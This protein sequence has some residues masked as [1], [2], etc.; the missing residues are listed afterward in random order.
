[1][2]DTKPDT[3]RLF[4]ALWPDADTR[5]ALEHLQQQLQLDG[6][7]T[8]AANFHI[9][10]A[11]LGEQPVASLPV[12][13]DILAGVACPSLP[14]NID[15]TGYF[16]RLRLAWLGMRH[17]P[18]ELL[19]LHEGLLA[20]LK[21][22]RIAIKPSPGFRPHVTLAR[23]TSAPPPMPGAPIHWLADEVV[24]AESQVSQ[25]PGQGALYRV[26]ATKKLNKQP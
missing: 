24:L 15:C 5:A 25:Q 4:Y 12:L 9:T 13:E 18:E 1:M 10:L 22:A 2:S 20:E 8:P 23:N 11:F 14:L 7:A 26:I 21:A 16:S 19:N 6:R 3:R 17:P